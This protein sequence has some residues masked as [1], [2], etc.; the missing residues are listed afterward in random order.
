MLPVEV[1][2]A[3]GVTADSA[4]PLPGGAGECWRAGALVLKP[5]HGPVAGSWLA[6]V[7]VGLSGPGFQVPQPVRAADGSWVVDGWA[8]WTA[9]DGEPAP[10]K[11]WPELVTAS[12]AFHAALVGVPVP[13]WVG[14]RRD[15]WAVA[16]RAVWE[17]A[18]V[19]VAP[20]LADLVGALMAAC[21]PLGLPFQ[22]V[23]GDIAGNVLFADGQPP[24][25]IDFSPGWRPAGYALAVAA[26]DVLAW[27]AAPPDILDEL[28]DDEEIDQLL[29]RAL[30]WRLVTESLGRPDADSRRAVRQANEP[31]V[32]L[33]LSR[34]TGR[35]P[36]VAPVTDNDLAES[37]SRLLGCE[38]TGLRPVVGGHSRALTRLA[39]RADGGTVFIKAGSEL[40]VTVYE[41]LRGRSFLPRQLAAE[42][43]PVS[44]LVLEALDP[45]GW[46]REWTP[47]LI[48]ATREL[49]HEVHTLPAPGVPALGAVANPWDAIAADPTRLLRMQ[50]CT[51]EWL[52][53]HLDVLRA[54]A[55]A[56]PT[57]AESLIHRD[58]RAANLWCGDGRLVLVDWAS[59]AIGD[60]WLDHHLWLV[61]VHAEGGPAPDAAEGPHAAGHAALIAGQQPLLTPSR[62]ADP[63]LFAQR[64]RRLEVALSWAARLLDLEPSYQGSP[65]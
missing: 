32:D 13:R 21:R 52:S 20:E 30:A 48:D 28:A 53:K 60:P 14:R 19:D 57:S 31:V 17:G 41:A 6:E 55:T 46:V 40:E 51:K 39:D 10:V 12:R 58:V 63:A 16:D 26:V 8:A 25:V 33:L 24:A 27:S 45:S 37:T 9:L 50:V 1:C 7:F 35:P 59:A 62:D 11:R 64:R 22:L 34:V 42:R 56:A 43:E 49:L 61:A 5:G 29:L 44:M 38:I 2:A 36:A 23:H 4:V 54:A 3:F 47:Q 18:S 65:T 15:R